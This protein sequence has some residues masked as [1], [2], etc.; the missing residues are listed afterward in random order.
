MAQP[1]QGQK[2]TKTFAEPEV[3]VEFK[4]DVHNWMAAYGAVL[5]NP[6]YAVSDDKGTFTI[7]DLPAGTYE[8]E[9]WHEKY[10][11]QSMSVTVGASDTK[12]ADFTF[13]GN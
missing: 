13:N 4:C 12:T 11:V 3:M 2:A 6:F 7:K 1:K 10:G 5:D 8:L 9:A